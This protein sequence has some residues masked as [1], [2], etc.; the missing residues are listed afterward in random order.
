MQGFFNLPCSQPSKCQ[1]E[2]TE[3]NTIKVTKHN[4]MKENSFTGVTVL[5]HASSL[6]LGHLPR[7]LG[8][9]RAVRCQI[10]KRLRAYFE[11]FM[12]TF[13]EI[14]FLQSLDE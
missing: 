10:A 9:F 2:K 1:D 11:P 13:H 14:A 3:L 5:L 6:S 4:E 8:E 12:A 7:L